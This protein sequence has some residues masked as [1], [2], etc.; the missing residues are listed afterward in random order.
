MEKGA[1]AIEKTSVGVVDNGRGVHS[2]ASPA[3]KKNPPLKPSS[4]PSTPRESSKT[5]T[6]ILP[7]S[8]NP[9]YIIQ[10]LWL[11]KPKGLP[12]CADLQRRLVFFIV[13]ADR[14]QRQT[15]HRSRRRLPSASL[16]ALRPS[17][18]GLESM[19]TSS[20][21]ATQLR[22]IRGL[23]SASSAKREDFSRC[24]PS[25]RLF[26]SASGIS[27]GKRVTSDCESSTP[28]RSER[29]SERVTAAAKGQNQRAT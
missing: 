23:S 13:A 9:F 2:A 5:S 4:S 18:A 26:F 27:A 29:S 10:C 12:A 1:S 22:H 7:S 21:S 15:V 3:S 14:R 8:S 17:S 6:K 24:A 16:A 11:L 20:A 19:R 28:A 25:E